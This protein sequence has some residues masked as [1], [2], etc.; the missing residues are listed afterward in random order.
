MS[1]DGPSELPLHYGGKTSN[2]ELVKRPSTPPGLSSPRRSYHPS[3]SVAYSPPE[4]TPVD[5]HQF[6]SF[7]SENA[8]GSGLRRKP[9]NSQR[10]YSGGDYERERPTFLNESSSRRALRSREDEYYS[11]RDRSSSLK[12]EDYLSHGHPDSYER[13]RPPRTYR[14]TEGWERGPQSSTKQ[15]FEE[16]RGDYRDH[17][18]GRDEYTSERKRALSDDESIDGYN[19]DSHKKGNRAT[20][21]FRNLTKEERAEVMRLPWTQWMDSSTKNRKCP[22]PDRQETII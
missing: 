5:V 13:S 16:S 2:G 8:R 22:K 21:D 17:D 18:R 4:M 11:D 9:T 14:N 3:N 1:G 6:S 20:I 15:Y 7:D 10:R 19:Y 12:R